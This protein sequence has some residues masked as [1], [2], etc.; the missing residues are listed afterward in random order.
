[1]HALQHS[2]KEGIVEPECEN[3]VDTVIENILATTVTRDLVQEK[4]R[5][6][7]T[8]P[9]I[10]DVEIVQ[11]KQKEVAE[12]EGRN[13][14]GKVADVCNVV[15]LEAIPLETNDAGPSTSILSLV[16]PDF[17]K[18]LRTIPNNDGLK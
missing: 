8:E 11:S 17:E 9:H 5:D 14:D 3:N 1:M 12:Q 18:M 10:V 7:H 6:D 13:M 4:T 2:W 15:A 16:L